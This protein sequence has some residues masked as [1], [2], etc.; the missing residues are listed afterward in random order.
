MD[1]DEKMRF[2]DNFINYIHEVWIDG[3]FPPHT[4]NCNGRNNDNTNN[5]IERYNGILNRL[6]QVQHPNPYVLICHFF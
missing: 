5:N 1:N 3:P 4:W 2:R 6:I